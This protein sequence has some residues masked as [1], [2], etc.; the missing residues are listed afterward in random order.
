MKHVPWGYQ[1]IVNANGCTNTTNEGAIRAF[2]TDLCSGIDM[3]RHGEPQLTYFDELGEKNGWTLVQLIK[4]SSLVVHFCDDGKIFL[5]LFS[6]KEFDP[7]VVLGALTYYFHPTNTE[8]DI[9]ERDI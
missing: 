5:D 6:C 2:N 3:I 9:I 1:M 7:E 4:T 8:Y